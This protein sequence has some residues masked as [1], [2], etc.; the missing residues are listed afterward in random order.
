MR[1]PAADLRSVCEL[2][3]GY[4]AEIAIAT[5]L[6]VRN[7]HSAMQRLDAG[8]LNLPPFLGPAH[9]A[10]ASHALGAALHGVNERQPD[11]VSQGLALWSAAVRRPCTTMPLVLPASACRRVDDPRYESPVYLATDEALRIEENGTSLSGAMSL[12]A[13]SRLCDH[14]G[15]PPGLIVNL[16]TPL[17]AGRISSYSLTGYPGTV[18]CDFAPR[19]IGLAESIVHEWGHNLFN[20][21]LGVEQQRF[22]PDARFYSPWR[23]EPRPAFGMAHAL[24]T[25]SLLSIFFDELGRQAVHVKDRT[26]ARARLRIEQEHL[27]Y[28]RPIL[29]WLTGSIASARLR[30]LMDG[31]FELA[32]LGG[33]SDDK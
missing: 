15:P 5:E 10:L 19:S 33:H 20:A 18:F 9:A 4:Q 22:D 8:P 6:R 21:I 7:I 12:I 1:L 31:M 26:Y 11:C 27:R 32:I 24:F 25:F 23:H 3:G 14:L 16:G 28:S 2:L 29:D 13:L 30:D 17:D